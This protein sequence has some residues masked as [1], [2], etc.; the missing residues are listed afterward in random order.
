[1]TKY[2]IEKERLFWVGSVN[3]L[4][5]SETD[6]SK[7]V[8]IQVFS[9]R[10]S[11]PVPEPSPWLRA[12]HLLSRTDVRLFREF[13]ALGLGSQRWLGLVVAGSL[14][15]TACVKRRGKWTFEALFEGMAGWFGIQPSGKLTFLLK[16]AIEIVSFPMKN[17]D[18]PV[19]YVSH[20]QRV[21]HY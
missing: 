14:Q 9:K 11:L 5:Q 12:V 20:Y 2:V 6:M 4:H 16:M 1:M 21:Y 17:D 3:H 18:F 7:L 10:C 8:K 19:R 13:G 15:G